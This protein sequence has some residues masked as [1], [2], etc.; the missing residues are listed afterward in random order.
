MKR[1][2]DMM[3]YKNAVREELKENILSGL[4]RSVGRRPYAQ[5]F[6]S[7]YAYS[8]KL[9]LADVLPGKKELIKDGK[10]YVMLNLKLG[11]VPSARKFSEPRYAPRNPSQGHRF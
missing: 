8:E 6:A 5:G 1:E 10:A 9:K 4:P 3:W 2:R 7:D 11:A